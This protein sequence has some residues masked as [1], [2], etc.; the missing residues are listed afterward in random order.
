MLTPSKAILASSVT[1]SSRQERE[2]AILQF[3]GGA[4]G[5]RPALRDLEQPQVDRRIRPE[6]LAGCCAEQ[7]GVSDLPARSGDRHVHWCGAHPF[8]L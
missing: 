3:E 6:E 4:F 2:R 5:R 8:S 7:Q 1:V